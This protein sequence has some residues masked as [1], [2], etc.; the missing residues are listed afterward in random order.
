MIKKMLLLTIIFIFLFVVGCTEAPIEVS[1]H[2]HDGDVE[3]DHHDEDD[4]NLEEIEEQEDPM[5]LDPVVEVEEESTVKEFK[6]TAKKWEFVPDTIT[7]NEG[8]TVKLE[9]ESIDVTH[10][11]GLSAFGINEN[12]K[13]GETVEVEFVADKKGEFTFICS[14]FCGSG[15]GAM[16]GT[17]VVE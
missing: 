10:G 9:I 7:V 11:F 1:D 3:A 6:M 14:V 2:G 5:D 16:K 17:L 15:H 12:L 8:D 4:V 13:S